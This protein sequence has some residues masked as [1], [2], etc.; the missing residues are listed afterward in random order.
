MLLGPIMGDV[1]GLVLTEADRQR[2]MHPLMGGV[3]FFARNYANPAQLAAL[4][5]SIR[6]L[7]TPH[8]MIVVDHEGGRVQRFRE[9][10]TTIP[11]MRLLG[12]RWK[13]NPAEA[14][15]LA[16]AVGVVIGTEL[17]AHGLDFSFAPVLDLDWGGSTIIGD[18]SFGRDAETVA[19]LAGEVIAGLAA[20]GVASCAKHFPGHGFVK[21]DSHHEIPR[22]TRSFNDIAGDD[23][24]PFKLLADKFDSVMPAH[25]IFEQVDAMPAGFSSHWLKNVL[26]DQLGFRGVIFSDDLTM[27]GA[28]VVG[29]DVARAMAALGAGCD[30]ALLC[31]DQKRCSALLA[32]LVAEGVSPDA[33]RSEHLT[34]MHAK[35]GVSLSDPAYLQAKATVAAA[36]GA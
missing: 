22:D 28:S 35:R 23:M 2:L 36:V 11:P 13:A 10:F 32:G 8:L 6:E 15:K 30:M 20:V 4:A 14:R 34:R 26:R 21:A 29:G 19:T 18:R 17:V 5:A 24:V 12:E 27:E 31:N 7:R 25:I 3:I 33:T 1:E 16:H 9:G